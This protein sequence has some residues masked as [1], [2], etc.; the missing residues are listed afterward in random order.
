MS[1]DIKSPANWMCDMDIVNLNQV[2][3]GTTRSHPGFPAS[4]GRDRST[5][6]SH[7]VMELQSRGARIRTLM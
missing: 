7:Q 2:M 1:G 5:V 4:E 6:K 3:D